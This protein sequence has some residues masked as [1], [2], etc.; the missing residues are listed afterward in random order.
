MLPVSLDKAAWALHDYGSPQR[1]HAATLVRAS[2]CSITAFTWV[3]EASEEGQNCHRVA[4]IPNDYTLRHMRVTFYMARSLNDESAFQKTNG[5]KYSMSPSRREILRGG[6]SALAALVAT[7][8]AAVAELIDLGSTAT[9]VGVPPPDEQQ[10]RALDA[11]IR[12]WW[13]E[14]LIHATEEDIR[15]DESKSLL[16]LPFPYLR[17]SPGPKGT[18]HEQFAYDTA[19]MNYALLAHCRLDVARNHI[20]NHLFLIERYGYAPNGNSVHLVTR[21]QIPFM[22]PTVWRYYRATKDLDLLYRAYPLLKHEYRH[23][24]NGPGH[25]TPTGLSTCR[26]ETDPRLSPEL[27]SE[28]EAFDF[29]PVFGADVRRCVPLAT[30]C[31]LVNYARVLALIGRALGRTEE[32]RGFVEEANHRAELIRRYCWDEKTGFFLEYDYIGRRQLPYFSDFAYLTLWSGVATRKQAARLVENLHLLEKP[33]G[34]ACTD[35][36]YPDPHSEAAYTVKGTHER[37][38]EGFAADAP[39]EYHGGGGILHYM[40]PAGWGS[41]QL[42]VMGGLDHYGY[43]GAARRIS[44]RFLTLLLEKYAKTGRLWEKYNVVDGSLILPNS[45]Y[46]VIPMHSFTAAAVV[47]LGR[48]HF[49]NQ[50]FTIM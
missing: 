26:D 6:M 8:P 38:Q 25:Q 14:D 36:A 5:V 44:A 2:K 32:S 30:N 10:W 39:A 50:P 11:Q 15:K 7:S 35:K 16:F 45:R 29:T 43:S 41:S 4:E 22:P 23:H 49:D 37:Y 19:F 1:F 40:Y 18:Y 9:P 46:G 20:L 12:G 47:L 42:L 21:S 3:I 28:A 17:V 48:R 33:Y 31:A 24:W 34:I 27:A 13:D